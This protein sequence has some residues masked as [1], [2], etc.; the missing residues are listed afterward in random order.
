VGSLV[1]FFD[2]GGDGNSFFF[3]HDLVGSFVFFFEGPF[4]AIDGHDGDGVYHFIVGCG[5]GH[6][7]SGVTLFVHDGLFVGLG[8]GY[9]FFF[10]HD[11]VD[12]VGSFV[13]F[14]H[15]LVGSGVSFTFFVHDVG[16]LVGLGDGHSFFDF[17]GSFESESLSD[18]LPEPLRESLSEPLPDA[19]AVEIS[20]FPK[21]L[22][23]ENIPSPRL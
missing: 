2:G 7:G 1:T 8:D 16:F 22:T 10:N 3:D 21:S 9:S 18:P 14:F 13:F 6:V 11:F 15:D 4:G 17:I 23:A 5:V 12:F 19:L 20:N